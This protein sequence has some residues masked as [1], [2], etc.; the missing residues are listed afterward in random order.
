MKPLPDDIG[1]ECCPTHDSKLQK[2]LD[3]VAAPLSIELG[4]VLRNI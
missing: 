2:K 3:R 1:C 4:K